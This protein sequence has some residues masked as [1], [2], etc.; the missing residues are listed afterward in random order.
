MALTETRVLEALKT[1]DDP[2]LHQD[3]VS[4]GMVAKTVID[5]GTVHVK[6]DLTTPAC[7]MK[8]RIEADVKA[9]LNALEGVERVDLEFGA[10]VRD[11]GKEALPGVK[12]VI[13]VGSG[14]G[15]VGKSTVAA[16]LAVS[17]TLE[18]ASVG[19][20]DA[21]IYG[22]SQA[23]MF[24]VEG[25]RL[26]ADD[27]KNI[28]PLRN[29]GVKLISIAN[30]VEDGQAL[31]WRGPILHGTLTQMIQQTVW[32][33]LDYL[34]VD[35]PPGTGDVQLSL[36]QL[37]TV[38][39]GVLVTTPQEMSLSDVKRAYTMMRKTHIPVLGVIEN[40]SWYT[41]PD[42]TRDYL[43]GDG[44]AGRWA[45]GEHVA[46]LGQVPISRE[47]RESGDAGTPLVLSHPDSEQ[48]QALRS[49]ARVL[50]GQVSIQ[51]MNTLPVV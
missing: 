14:K 10:Q 45:E 15:G 47:V 17:L 24:D 2:E 26:M 27:D 1:V 21:D 39:G 30:L 9:A 7:P 49:A 28:I 3:L 35:L 41:L 8:G 43:F 40:M 25:K 34:I 51:A 6:I 44:G 37:A 22:P 20:L 13:A 42:G 23:K 4:L 36:A 38:S 46:L 12:H 29:H 48:A 33:E 32:G 16:N 5:G 19:L 50:A 18:G 31:T 11:G